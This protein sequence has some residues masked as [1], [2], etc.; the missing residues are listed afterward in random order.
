MNGA[1]QASLTATTAHQ[2]RDLSDVSAT[3]LLTL[4]ARARASR[5]PSA[6][7]HDP[8]A[9]QLAAALTPHLDRANPLHRRLLD[10]KLPPLVVT[11]LG[12]RARRYD[13]YAQDFLHRHP[14]GVIVNLGCG[15]DTRFERLDAD[16]ADSGGSPRV[17]ELDL[18]PMIALKQ[19][20]IEPHARHP[21]LAASVL[22]FAWMDELDR[23]DD[24]RFLF[25]AEGLLMYFTPEEAK[26]LV[27]ALLARFAGSELVA[28]VFHER[29][30][31]PPWDVWVAGKMERQL[32]VG[33]SARFK[34]G[35][36]DGRDLEAW[37]PDL[38]F[39]DDW[40]F[41]DEQIPQLGF[42]RLL[43]RVDWIRRIQWNLHYQLG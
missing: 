18:P 29:W 21:L 19:G 24:R 8:A 31:R 39:L 9:Q 17:V 1:T 7:L 35:V 12:L 27:L 36:R 6:I 28:E 10:D 34:F 4:F 2:V 23:Y 43:G 13:D 37:H 14:Q 33:R 11:I 41:L 42:Y 30:L 32:N 38:R 40:S 3:A 25:L 26:A 5:G 16:M 20:L 22:D 15:L